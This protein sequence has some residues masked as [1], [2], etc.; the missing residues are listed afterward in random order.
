MAGQGAPS[1]EFTV[2]KLQDILIKPTIRPASILQEIS[3]IATIAHFGTTTLTATLQRQYNP[4][5]VLDTRWWTQ[6]RLQL[7]TYS[8]FTSTIRAKYSI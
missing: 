2:S 8:S 3:S 1:V 4:N 5:I 6:T 7:N